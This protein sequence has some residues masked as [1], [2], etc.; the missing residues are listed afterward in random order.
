VSGASFFN[1][2]ELLE[3]LAAAQCGEIQVLVA[4]NLDRFSRGVWPQLTEVAERAGL[5]LVTADGVID[6]ADDERELPADMYEAFAKEQRR[7]TVKKS[8]AS[9]AARVRDGKHVGG[10]APFGHRIAKGERG[11]VLVLDSDEQLAVERAFALLLDEGCSPKDAAARLN[12]EGF[13]KRGAR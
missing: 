8:M 13:R 12:A 4:Y 6:T 7:L 5:R 11:S 3:A 10:V 2:K 9:R 1:R